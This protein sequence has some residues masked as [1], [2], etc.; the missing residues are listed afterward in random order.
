MKCEACNNKKNQIKAGK[1][2]AGVQKYKWKIRGKY[3]IL[4]GKK[5]GYSE[6]INKQAIKLYL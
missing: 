4:E 2:K 3:Y 5:R 6:N 1:A